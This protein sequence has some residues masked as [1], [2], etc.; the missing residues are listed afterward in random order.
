LVAAESTAK[1]ANPI[2]RVIAR[3]LNLGF[4]AGERDI[5]RGQKVSCPEK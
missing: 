4:D 1:H 5:E 2:L 3:D